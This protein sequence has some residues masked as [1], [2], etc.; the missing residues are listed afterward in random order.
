MKTLPRIAF[1]QILIALLVIFV[2]DLLAAPV[3]HSFLGVGKANR[4]VI[5]NEQGEVEWRFDMPASDGWVLP[6]GNVL[7]ALYPTRDFPGG[8]VVEVN[9]RTRKIM[10]KYQGQQKEISTVQQIGEN[11]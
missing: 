1:F 3:T 6:D 8:G 5:V 4:V 9:R 2:P 7:L 10:W 11:R